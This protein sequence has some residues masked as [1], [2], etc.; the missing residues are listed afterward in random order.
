MKIFANMI[1]KQST[2]G[3]YG[4][5]RDSAV[6]IVQWGVPDII[7]NGT[8]G[9][10]GKVKNSRGIGVDEAKA[11]L[12]SFTSLQL[13]VLSLPDDF[14]G[15]PGGQRIENPLERAKRFLESKSESEN[16]EATLKEIMTELSKSTKASAETETS[17][18]FNLPPSA[19]PELLAVTFALLVHT[20]CELLEVGME[21]TA[22]CIRDAFQPIYTPQYDEEYRDLFQCNTTEQATQ[23]NTWNSQ[24]LEG[25]NKLK[26]IAVQVAQ[27]QLRRDDLHNHAKVDKSSTMTA[28]QKKEYEDKIKNYDR[29][30]Q[31]LKQ[32]YQ[33]QS[34]RARIAYER[35]HDLP[36]LRRARGVRWQ[37]TLS[38]QTYGLLSAFLNQS[39]DTLL[40]MS[41]LL[42]TKCELHIERRDPL[43]FVPACVIE[44]NTKGESAV[45]LARR[46]VRWAA[47][48]IRTED[49]NMNLGASLPFP[50]LELNDEYDD[51]QQASRDRKRVEFNRALLANGF[52]R[53]EAIDRKREFDVLPAE[54]KKRLKSGEE[55]LPV[56]GQNIDDAFKPSILMSSLVSAENGPTLKS[57]Q[58]SS[59]KASPTTDAAS[60]WDEPG[61]GLTCAKGSEPDGRRV[62][63][64]CDDSS[65][66]IYDMLSSSPGGSCQP[67][68]V[69]L[70]HKNGFPVFDV[71]WCRDGRCLISGGGDGTVR[72][73]DTAAVGPIGERLNAKNGSSDK[74]NGLE[75]VQ[76][77]EV[78]GARPE[79]A[80][81]S[82]G[83]ALAVYHGH[84]PGSPVWSVAFSPS[85]YYFASAGADAT[86]RL[87]VTDRPSPVRLFVG[88]TAANVNAVCWHP[89]CNY[90]LTGSDDRTCRLWDIQ[91]G[92]SVRLLT[93]CGAGV[94]QVKISPGGRYAVGADYSGTVYRWDLGNGKLVNKFCQPPNENALPSRNPH[95]HSL[96]FSACGNALA[97]GGDDCVV[98]LWDVQRGS[99]EKGSVDV[100]AP[101]ASFSTDTNLIMDLR[102]T[103]RNLLLAVGKV[104]NPIPLATG[105]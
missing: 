27:F 10:E 101:V 2:G 23:L 70:G 5:D 37:L 22:H 59:S 31:L 91:T 56:I 82:V 30:I 20:Y 41:T 25:I 89:N 44:D 28:Q 17:V 81:S 36:F 84:V 98:R 94:N 61:I 67:S 53:L 72:L 92:R 32:N 38:T 100:K 49:E 75:A 14:E 55:S 60:I 12:D 21:T 8:D 52:R 1:R 76:Q 102:F 11:Y 99:V 62:A 24:H 90:I 105:N 42:Q 57:R 93:G 95:I 51:A 86:A 4:Y 85:G 83:A 46:E 13:W 54:Q 66:R 34:E 71:D 96:S 3:G 18:T 68:T 35:M 97:T 9:S 43:P 78:P 6:P 69:L 45:D 7:P 103:R 19:K 87:W 74:S 15:T 48:A 64:G 29:R 16:K 40:A 39:D 50:K 65:I 88:H 33:E 73:W 63:V 26:S 80:E 79:K 104:V 58:P 77:L 47:P